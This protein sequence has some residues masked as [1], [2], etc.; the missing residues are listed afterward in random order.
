MSISDQTLFNVEKLNVTFL[1]WG[2]DF[3]E[4][5]LKDTKIALLIIL[6]RKPEPC[7]FYIEVVPLPS[8]GNKIV[9]WTALKIPIW[10]EKHKGQVCFVVV[11]EISLFRVSSG[12]DLSD[13]QGNFLKI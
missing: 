11:F 10:K 8:Y 3:Q 12:I 9:P 6:T 4:K 13:M 5:T 1:V 2:S 7:P